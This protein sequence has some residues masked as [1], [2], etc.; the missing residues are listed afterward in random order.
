M[1]LIDTYKSAK[2]SSSKLSGSV[3]FAAGIF[4]SAVIAEIGSTQQL[5]IDDAAEGI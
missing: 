1:G 2:R 4:V 3:I 5:L